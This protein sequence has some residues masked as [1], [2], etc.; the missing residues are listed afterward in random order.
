MSADAGDVSYLDHYSERGIES[1]LVGCSIQHALTAFRRWQA[2]NSTEVSNSRRDI[3]EVRSIPQPGARARA[4][5]QW[6]ARAVST[7]PP[8]ALNG[9]ESCWKR[10]MD[11][12]VH[13]RDG[14]RSLAEHVVLNMYMLCCLLFVM[15]VNFCTWTCTCRL[16]RVWTVT[17]VDCYNNNMT[18]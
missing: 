15:C 5:V 4:V 7:A 13:V 9:T 1:T 3:D 18:T 17:Q 2:A 11:A 10:L 12:G 8:G 16:L 14:A 6:I